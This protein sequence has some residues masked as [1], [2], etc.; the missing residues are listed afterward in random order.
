MATFSLFQSLRKE[1]KDTR[2]TMEERQVIDRAKAHLMETKKISEDD[3][4]HTIRKQA[5]NS[6][7]RLVERARQLLQR[8]TTW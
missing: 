4:Y 2:T 7:Q 1:L 3:A 5:M 6:K 8:S